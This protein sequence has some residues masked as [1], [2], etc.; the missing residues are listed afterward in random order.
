[1]IQVNLNKEIETKFNRLL[2]HYQGDYN[3]MFNDVIEYYV[4][5]LKKGMKNI[6]LD[7]LYFENRYSLTTEK[8]YKK[9][10]KGELGDE[11][12]DYIQW[13]GEYEIW[14]DHKKDFAELI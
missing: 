8:F 11:N 12:N 9:F 13:C 1:M 6:E 4:Q 2:E 5:E 7:L 10:Q 3:N 14:L